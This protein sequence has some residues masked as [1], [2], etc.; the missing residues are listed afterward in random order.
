MNHL[1]AN[2]VIPALTHVSPDVSSARHSSFEIDNGTG[3]ISVNRNLQIMEGIYVAGNSAS[4]YDE[5]LGRRRV[6]RYDH[7]LKTGELVGYNMSRPLGSKRKSYRYQPGFV[8]NLNKIG[9]QVHGIGII[10]ANYKTVGVWCSNVVEVEE[11]TSALK[12]GIVYYIKEDEVSGDEIVGCLLW[13]TPAYVEEARTLLS[14]KE[15]RA[16]I[17]LLGLK[18]KINIGP[19]DS[20]NIMIEKKK[21]MSVAEI[22][23]QLNKR[24]P[25]KEHS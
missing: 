25:R 2:Y 17:G 8:S 7:A 24:H 9:V 18:N 1:V 15:Q 21:V 16:I 19:A 22:S 14:S 3:G 4:W 5:S 12:K 20:L 6:D 11:H 10:D 13:N 23:E